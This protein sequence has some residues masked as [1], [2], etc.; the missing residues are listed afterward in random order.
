MPVVQNYLLKLRGSSQPLCFTLSS[1]ASGVLGIHPS[2]DKRDWNRG[3][4]N[5]NCREDEGKNF[6]MQISM[7][8]IMS[9]VFWDSEGFLLVEFL[10]RGVKFRAIYAD[11]KELK[12]RIRSFRT[13]RKLNHSSSSL[14]SRF[15]ATWLRFLAPWRIHSEGVV[16][17]MMTCSN[18]VRVE[19]RRLSIE[20]WRPA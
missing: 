16:L 19:L 4:L 13:S 2:G 14:Y 7:A 12:Q 6:K 15:S 3:L 5:R 20:F 11:I 18:S 10:K 17:R 8:N 1:S 9:G